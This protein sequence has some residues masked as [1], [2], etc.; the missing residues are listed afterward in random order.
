[1][2]GLSASWTSSWLKPREA[3]ICRSR[4]APGDPLANPTLP[5]P[6]TRESA[7]S[8]G[9][10]AAKVACQH[11]AQAGKGHERRPTLCSPRLVVSAALAPLLGGP[12]PSEAT[13]QCGNAAIDAAPYPQAK[14]YQ[15]A[16]CPPSARCLRAAACC[17]ASPG[18]VFA[19]KVAFARFMAR[20]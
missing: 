8:E 2:Q 9:S 3:F 16:S 14:H 12:C 19:Q 15:A 17:N 11:V 13:Q 10:T 4:P 5:Q 20:S 18:S 1:M 6:T 7:L